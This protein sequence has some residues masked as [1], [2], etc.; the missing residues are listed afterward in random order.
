MLNKLFSSSNCPGGLKDLYA[1]LLDSPDGTPKAS[2]ASGGVNNAPVPSNASAGVE[3]MKVRVLSQSVAGSVS[4]LRVSLSGTTGWQMLSKL[5]FSCPQQHSACLH[6]LQLSTVMFCV[7]VELS[8][9]SSLFFHYAANISAAAFEDIKVQYN[10]SRGPSAASCA[11][12]TTIRAHCHISPI[13]TC[14]MVQQTW[15]TCMYGLRSSTPARVAA[16]LRLVHA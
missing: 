12:I 4:S 16:L 13:A 14:S 3:M 11:G 1:D 8:C 7:Q 5:T 9:D 10:S 15:T 6:D 2:T